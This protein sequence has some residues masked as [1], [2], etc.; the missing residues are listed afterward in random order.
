M[1][2]LPF[3][4]EDPLLTVAAL[5]MI[6][7]PASFAGALIAVIM[8]PDSWPLQMLGYAIPS[9]CCW[10]LLLYL[11]LSI[12]DRDDLEIVFP[13]S[14]FPV[15]ISPMI[16]I[17]LSTFTDPN[18]YALTAVT[19]A[20][21]I[22]AFVFSWAIYFRIWVLRRA[23]RRR[24]SPTNSAGCERSLTPSSGSCSSIH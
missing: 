7:V 6:V 8:Y 17:F 12:K 4:S 23:N 18:D 21:P 14:I 5:L 3:Y 16:S 15:A 20:S 19:I 11:I 10:L 1:S 2:R 22:T 24:L 9:G 13:L